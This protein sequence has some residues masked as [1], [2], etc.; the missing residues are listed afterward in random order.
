MM[1]IMERSVVLHNGELSE[2]VLFFWP[3]LWYVELPGPGLEPE[4]Q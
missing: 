1:V 4:S 3:C 2:T